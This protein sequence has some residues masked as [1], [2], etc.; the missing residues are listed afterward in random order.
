MVEEGLCISRVSGRHLTRWRNVR[1]LAMDETQVKIEAQRHSGSHLRLP[2]SW[3]SDRLASRYDESS[4]RRIKSW[5][6]SADI[7]GLEWRE[8]TR[9]GLP[10]SLRPSSGQPQGFVHGFL[11]DQNTPRRIELPGSSDHAIRE[12]SIRYLLDGRSDMTRP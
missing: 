10:G 4:L 2:T 1:A 12:S 11:A 8:M 5:P 9:P 7:M 3:T 6:L